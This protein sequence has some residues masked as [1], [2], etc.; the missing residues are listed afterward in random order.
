MG[1]LH[2]LYGFMAIMDA[3]KPAEQMSIET[4][5]ADGKP[6]NPYRPKFPEL[7]A[8]KSTRIGFKGDFNVICQRDLFCNPIQQPGNRVRFA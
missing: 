1:Y 8:L 6:I 4:L 3:P 5:Y 2:G 7:G